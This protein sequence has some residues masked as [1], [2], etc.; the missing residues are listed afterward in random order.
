MLTLDEIIKN[1]SSF[2]LI[3]KASSRKVDGVNIDSRII[4]AGE[5]FVAI[6]GDKY[7]A[8]DFVGQ[9]WQKGVSHFLIDKK[10]VHNPHLKTLGDK[11][12]SL[13]V[14]NDVLSAYQDLSAFYLDKITKDRNAI[15]IAIT[16]SVGKTTTKDLLAFLLKKNYLVFATDKNENNHIGVPKNIFQLKPIDQTARL[17]YIFELGMNHTG[18]IDRLSAI[19]KPTI[20]LITNVLPI[21]LANFK[22]TKRIAKAKCEIF[23]HQTEDGIAFLNQKSAHLDV[24]KKYSKHLKNVYI[25]SSEEIE[26]I[27]ADNSSST[28]MRAGLQDRRTHKIYPISMETALAF[29]VNVANVSTALQVAEKLDVNREVAL[30]SL[31]GFIFPKRHLE[32]IKGFSVAKALK[33]K[34]STQDSLDFPLVIDDAY[35]ANDASIIGLVSAALRFAKLIQKNKHDEH[36]LEPLHVHFVLGDIFELGRHTNK[37]HRQLAKSLNTLLNEQ[38]DNFTITKVICAVYC[39]GKSMKI[40]YDN[41]FFKKKF[42]FTEAERTL[43]LTT[44]KQQVNA[45]PKSMIAFKA[46]HGMHFDKLIDDFLS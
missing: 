33:K 10:D 38:Q 37:I 35:N 6:R 31:K 23:K 15:R 34:A 19:V 9:A 42:Y 3:D 17:I 27:G 16:G 44:L 11:P 39:I 8:V 24:Q 25:F 28:Q 2:L 4:K 18:E 36:S 22:S 30:A 40:C 46:S 26:V 21:H 5:L 20:S 29:S 32:I 13:I 12:V 1:T 43:V 45:Y 41:L 14:A 7:L